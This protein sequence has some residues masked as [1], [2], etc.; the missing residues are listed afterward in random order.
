MEPPAFVPLLLLN[1]ADAENPSGTYRTGS[2]R[3]L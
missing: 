2:L 1:P 3:L